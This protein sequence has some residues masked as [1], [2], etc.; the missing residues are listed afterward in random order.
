[1]IGFIIWIIGLILAIKAVLEIMKW[2]VDG[3]KKLLVAILVLLTS[4]IGL[5]FYYFWGRDNLP[6]MLK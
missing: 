2:K 5:I 4:W 1:M 6:Q 3:V